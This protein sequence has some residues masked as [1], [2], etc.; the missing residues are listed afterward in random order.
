MENIPID[1]R[2]FAPRGFQILDILGRVAVKR[3]V[4]PHRQR[5][6]EDTTIATID[7]VPL[8]QIPFADIG[9]VLEDFLTN[10]TRVAFQ[11]IQQ[12]HFG[13]TYIQFVHVRDRKRLVKTSP[14]PSLN[15]KVSF[16]KH[17]RGR[18]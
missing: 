7:H 16:V 5:Q 15:V 8:G 14:I 1:P 17:D 2:P 9:K 4:V 11:S 13:S 10:Q 3:V 18:N 12:C 6:N